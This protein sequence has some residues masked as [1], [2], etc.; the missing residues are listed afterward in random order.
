MISGPLRVTLPVQLAAIGL[1]TLF[2]IKSS[3]A[4][5][6]SQAKSNCE[7]RLEAYK[8]KR[9]EFSRQS[10]NYWN[11]VK[12]KRSERRKKVRASI[13][14]SRSDYVLTFPPEY[15]GPKKPKCPGLAPD[16]P[17]KKVKPKPLPTVS[18][19]LRSAKSEYGFVPKPTTEIGYKIA[20][21]REAVS[22]G[23]N[24]D[25]I[26][27]V[28][29]L[30]T[31]GIGPYARQSGI[32][33]TNQ[34]CKPIAAKGRAASTALGYVQLLAANSAVVAY[35]NGR[36]FAERFEQMARTVGPA[37]AGELRRKAKLLRTVVR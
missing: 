8:K 16:K 31:G 26:V 34:N 19:F 36:Q 2:P 17:V 11:L 4:Q 24:A 35:Y 10:A 15:K 28:Y 3:Q 13:E 29:A 12:K 14:L 23:L 9:R 25:Q 22:V 20:V 6:S 7:L 33:I 21:A 30:E 27:G 18:N 5:T 37:R 32:F 1:I